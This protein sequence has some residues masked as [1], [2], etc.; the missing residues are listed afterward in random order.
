MT[1]IVRLIHLCPDC[2]REL[3]PTP[4]QFATPGES[5]E[6]QCEHC[7]W[8]GWVVFYVPAERLLKP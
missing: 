7:F 4:V 3:P 1:T 6:V 5:E 2:K 8:R